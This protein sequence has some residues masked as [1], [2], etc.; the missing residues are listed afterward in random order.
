MKTS[1]TFLFA[2]LQIGNFLYAQSLVVDWQQCYGGSEVDGGSS[3]IRTP[4]GYLLFGTTYSSN[5]DFQ[6]THGNGDFFVIWTDSVGNL[7]SVKTYGGTELD[8]ASDIK[9]TPDGGFVMFGSTFSNNFDVDGNHGSSDLWVVK[10]DDSG[11]IQWQKCLGGSSIEQEGMN[12]E[13]LADSGF[14][15]SGATASNDGDVT[16]FHGFYDYW[17]VR[18]DKNGS[19]VWEYCYGGTMADWCHYVTNTPDEGMILAGSTDTPNGDVLCDFHGGTGD[20]WIIKLDSLGN[21]EWQSCYGGSGMDNLYRIIVTPEG[22]YLCT[23]VTNSNDGQVSGNHGGFDFWVVRLDH[24]GTL[25]WQ[26][27]F[28]GSS[29]D[30]I[31]WISSSSD[32]NYLI[33]GHTYSNDG[34]VTGNHS[35]SGFQ[36]IWLIKISPT[37][38]MIWEQCIG[39]YG[40]DGAGNLIEYP[41]GEFTIIGFTSNSDNSGDVNCDYHGGLS[42]IW[43]VH[44]IDTNYIGINDNKGRMPIV[45]VYPNPASSFITIKYD[46]QSTTDNLPMTLFNG[47]GKPVG[48]YSLQGNKGQVTIDLKDFSVGVYAYI[49][50]NTNVSINGRFIIVK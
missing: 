4:S 26:K 22:G 15:C 19:L 44:L 46:F 42:D 17:P 33:V 8:Y 3:L 38:Q 40:N 47:I 41:N 37:G 29:N 27:C 35:I 7:L 14:L 16:G 34:D 6:N 39:G 45:E 25:I 50:Q 12:I 20:A 24:L 31:D 18:L 23:G 11:L 49:L 21:I 48:T 5:G 36:D 32:G 28:G 9:A 30:A 43:L 13:I 2:L 10:V 1:L